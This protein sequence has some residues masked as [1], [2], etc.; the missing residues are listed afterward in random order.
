[1]EDND[2]SE[3]ERKLFQSEADSMWDRCESSLRPKSPE[4]NL[5]N[6]CYRRLT[7]TEAERSFVLT[8]YLSRST[9]RLGVG[10]GT[11]LEK[12]MGYETRP[13]CA[14]LR[15]CILGRMFKEESNP[16][17]NEPQALKAIAWAHRG[18]YATVRLLQPFIVDNIVNFLSAYA[19][20]LGPTMCDQPDEASL[21]KEY[22]DV[23]QITPIHDLPPLIGEYS[24]TTNSSK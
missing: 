17:P 2:E 14:S 4:L 9:V 6:E 10:I 8:D 5:P 7:G 18:R 23:L 3:Q 20:I 21:L 16:F 12:A 11:F 1:M 15:L 19:I 24:C 13:K 22:M